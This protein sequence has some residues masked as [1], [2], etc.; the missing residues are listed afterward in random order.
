MQHYEKG[1]VVGAGTFGVVR[2]AVEKETGR[3][4]AL[5]KIR[6]GT[7]ASQG[8]SFTALR[9]I[10]LLLELHHPNIV[11]LF[12]VFVHKQNVVLAME[13]A[14][15]D[16]ERVI[17]DRSLM[18][19]T[20]DVKG[21]LVQLVRGIELCHSH[22]ILHRDLKPSNLLITSDGVLKIADF[23]LARFYASPPPERQYTSQVVTR[24]YRAPELLY[25]ARYYSASI[26]MWSVGCIFAE[27]MLRVP[28]FA[29]DS[30]IDQLGKIF[31]ALGT[32]TEANWPGEF[33]V[34]VVIKDF[35]CLL[36]VLLLISSC[37]SGLTLLPDYLPFQPST[38]T[39]MRQLF[40]TAS[41]D[42]LDLLASLLRFNPATRQSAKE[43]LSHAYFSAPPLASP[44]GKA[45]R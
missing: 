31:A 33:I 17:K 44:P 25:G 36:L 11:A 21:Y 2:R 27:L 19:S 15:F 40:P 41:E 39:P 32:P 42:A 4:V 7:S 35:I 10:K 5:K 24:W 28:Y 16:L 23:G 22:W 30:D 26:D 14:P 13:F 34:V 29:G 45:C 38:G 9:E 8:V 18:L 37:S 12:N 3:V 43:T 1:A 20:A 6:V